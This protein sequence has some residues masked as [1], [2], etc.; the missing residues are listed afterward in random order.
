M[1]KIVV[2]VF[3]LLACHAQ[4]QNSTPSGNAEKGKSTFMRVGCYACHGTVGQGGTGPK[5]APN[6]MT[7]D[8]LT[9]YVRKPAGMPPY[10]AKVLSDSDV[11]DIRAYLATVPAPPPVSSIPLLNQ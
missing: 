2:A 1:N 8:R 4:A 5:L 10:A 6:P 9:A 3:V 7:V 11:A